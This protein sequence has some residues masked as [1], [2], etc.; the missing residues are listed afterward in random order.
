MSPMPH[1]SMKTFAKFTKALTNMKHVKF[2]N[3]CQNI[4]TASSP[5]DI[6]V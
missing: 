5:I 3:V 1:G 4:V 2:S 6:F